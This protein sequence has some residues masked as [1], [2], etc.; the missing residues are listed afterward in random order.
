[1]DKSN[2]KIPRNLLDLFVDY[3]TTHK[4][5]EQINSNDKGGKSKGVANANNFNYNK[6]FDSNYNK[7]DKYD[8]SEDPAFALY[9]KRR[10]NFS[11]KNINII[12]E[13][14][15]LN[16]DAKPFYPK[17]EEVISKEVDDGFELI[18]SKLSEID[19]NNIKEYVP[20][21]F[22]IVRKEN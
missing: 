4:I 18:R 2:I 12:N 21:N 13:F 9:L 14:F 16:V 22:K 1:M 19:P 17:K 20:K 5:Y 11:N 15:K 10:N 3:C 6:K 7:F 8:D